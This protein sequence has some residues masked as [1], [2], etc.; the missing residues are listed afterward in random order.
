MAAILEPTRSTSRPLI[1]L[2]AGLLAA[3]SR[4]PRLSRALGRSRHAL[5]FRTFP[6]DGPPTWDRQFN[7]KIEPRANVQSAG[8]SLDLNLLTVFVAIYELGNRR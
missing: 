8:C 7:V 5:G 3:A 1:F 6:P 2:R 4:S